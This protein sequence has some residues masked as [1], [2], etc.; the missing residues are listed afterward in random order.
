[1]EEVLL[2]AV[3]FILIFAGAVIWKFYDDFKHETK[4]LRKLHSRR[5]ERD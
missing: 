5:R 4:G 3:V 2:L 1:M